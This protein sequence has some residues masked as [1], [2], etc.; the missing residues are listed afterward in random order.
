MAR[1]AR[2]LQFLTL[3]GRLLRALLA[4]RHATLVHMLGP[5]ARRDLAVIRET[6]RLAPLLLGDGAALQ[7]QPLVRAARRLGGAMAEA[8]VMGGGTARLICEAKGEAPLHLFDLFETL[9]G[10]EGE[11]G[12][13]GRSADL[14]RHFGKVHVPSAEVEAL[15]RPYPCVH[16]H[17]GVFPDSARGMEKERFSFVHIDLDLEPSTHDAIEYFLPLMLPG[18]IILGD[19]YL[20][21]GVRRAFDTCLAGR[22][23]TAIPT[24]WGQV[25]VIVRP[26]A[27]GAG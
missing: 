6:R 26:P 15:L 23:H 3:R 17:K 12:E 14:R 21:P 4:P 27:A 13:T 11:G 10:P 16:L 8:G 20:D 7:I 19:D 24:P 25:I 22:P 2:N 1:I 18:G 9:Q 5:E